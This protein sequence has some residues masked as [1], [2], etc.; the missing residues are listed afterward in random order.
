M[1]NPP[2]RSGENDW[3]EFAG[4]GGSGPYSGKS[5]FQAGICDGIY[6]RAE[7]RAGVAADRIYRIT[8]GM[9]AELIHE[10]QRTWQKGSV[11]P[12]FV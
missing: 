9:G 5:M 6:N 7:M 10:K 3:G 12:T 2:L 8:I 1:M 11:F 4:R